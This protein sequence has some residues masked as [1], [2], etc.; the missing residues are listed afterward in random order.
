LPEPA[1]YQP[2]SISLSVRIL[3]VIWFLALVF[4]GITEL[5]I[6][7]FYL[8]LKR[9]YFLLD[10]FPVVLVA[11]AFFL[12]SIPALLTLIDHYDKR[13]N[14]ADYRYF[15][16]A[17]WLIG[18][19]FFFIAPLS[20]IW[21]EV[22]PAPVQAFSTRVHGFAEN[23]SVYSESYKQYL[24]LLDICKDKLFSIIIPMAIITSLVF[25]W[26]KLFPHKFNRLFAFLL[27]FV[28]FYFSSFIFITHIQEFL[29][30]ETNIGNG[31]N[32][33]LIKAKTE[34]GT[35]SAIFLTRFSFTGLFLVLGLY[36]L[37]CVLTGKITGL[38]QP[39][40]RG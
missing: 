24:P 30:G 6:G 3:C 16:K 27:F 39:Y 29:N 33:H 32:K 18:T 5:A 34:P 36:G 11:F 15:K 1:R 19:F 23:Y 26:L 12:W 14:E 9:S 10:G 40:R 8:P 21:I 25:A 2:N 7:H 20:A 4:Y 31:Q 13:D 17:C 38:N 22:Y 28:V 35:F 37:I